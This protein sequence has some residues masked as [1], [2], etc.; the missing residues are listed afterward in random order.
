MGS[1]TKHT[2]HFV[3]SLALLFIVLASGCSMESIDYA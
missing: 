1:I 3:R 2:S